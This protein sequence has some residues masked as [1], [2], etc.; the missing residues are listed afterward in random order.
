MMFQASGDLFEHRGDALAADAV[1]DDPDRLQCGFNVVIIKLLLAVM[2]SAPLYA[3]VR[4]GRQIIAH[5]LY[6]ALFTSCAA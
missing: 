1:H 2:S 6:V 5:S 4:C 3:R